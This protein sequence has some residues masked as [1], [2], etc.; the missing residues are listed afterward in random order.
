MSSAILGR[1]MKVTGSPAACQQPPMKQPTEPAPRTATLSAATVRGDALI[2]EPQARGRFAALPENVD[3]HS[4]AWVPIAADAEPARLHLGCEPL[5]DADGNILVEAAMIAE[6]AQ[7]QLQALALDDRLARRIVDHDMG[8]VRLAGHRA[9]R[10]ELGRGEAYQIKLAAPWVRHIIEHRLFGRSGERAWLTEMCRLNHRAPLGLRQRPVD[11]RSSA[12]FQESIRFREM[13]AA[14]EPAV[15]RKRRWMRGLQNKVLGSV[16][17]CGLL[18][19]VASPQHEDD[20]LVLCI[21]LTDDGVG[22]PFP[23]AIAV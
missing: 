2:R 4:P 16:D 22:E 15:R 20:R 8:E 13:P 17:E 14:K 12:A 10:G 9:E 11:G 21:D 19:R 18:L 6:S 5:T 7:E 3:R 23:A 1:P